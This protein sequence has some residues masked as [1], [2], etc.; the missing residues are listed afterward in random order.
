MIELIDEN[1]GSHATRIPDQM[2]DMIV[3]RKGGF[4][5]TDSGLSCDTFNIIHIH[6]PEI[7]K[8]DFIEV[9]QS[10]QNSSKDFCIWVNKENLSKSTESVLNELDLSVQN[11][12]VGMVLDLERFKPK[13]DLDQTNITKVDSN[14]DL[15]KFARVLAANW[16]PPDQNVIEYYNVT[17][18]NFLNSNI[19]LFYYVHNGTPSTTVELFPSNAET[20]GIYGL[21]TL[22]DFR[23]Q[24]IGMKVMSFLLNHAKDSGYKN[25]ILQATEDGIGIYQKLG[26]ES[27]TTYFEYA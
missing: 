19:D 5:V 6:S 20:A 16:S 17:A 12:E 14:E 13:N 24:G 15:R 9:I 10:F 22:E 27:Y 8:D 4:T 3:S 21:A 25:L 23:G 26:F 1:F 18:N 11:E 2:Q 7:S